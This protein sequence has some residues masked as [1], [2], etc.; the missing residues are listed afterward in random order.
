MDKQ[1]NRREH[2]TFLYLTTIQSYYEPLLF[3]LVINFI[4]ALQYCHTNR[5][6][7]K[8]IHPRYYRTNYKTTEITA[9]I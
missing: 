5:L 6:H 3:Y 2:I 1:N 8:K 9:I 4:H 7:N